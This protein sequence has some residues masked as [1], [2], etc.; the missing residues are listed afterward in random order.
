VTTP[1][2]DEQPHLT[3]GGPGGEWL[4]VGVTWPDHKKLAY[5]QIGS[6]Q[7]HL[8]RQPLPGARDQALPSAAL[9]ALPG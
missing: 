6:A 7:L 5:W 3:W 1:F 8:Q 4:A 2:L 9:V